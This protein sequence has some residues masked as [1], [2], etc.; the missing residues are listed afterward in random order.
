MRTFRLL[1]VMSAIC[2]GFTGV[3]L[4]QQDVVTLANGA[5]CLTADPGD[6]VQI[7]IYVR[8][9]SG[10]P[11]GEDQGAGNQIQSFAIGIS[12]PVGTL[13]AVDVAAAGITSGEITI[14]EIKTPP[15]P[16]PAGGTKSWV[17]SYSENDS[18]TTVEADLPFN[19]DAA[20]P[21]DLIG[22][23]TVTVAGTATPGS[24]I[25]ITLQVNTS[26]L[27]EASTITESTATGDLML[28][29]TCIQITAPTITNTCPATAVATGGTGTGTVT[30]DSPQGTD[31]VVTLTSANPAVATVPATRT[32]PAGSTS[33]NYTVTGVSA[34]TTM[35]TATLPAGI[36]GASDGCNVTVQNAI[37]TLTPD[38]TNV[39]VGGT[40]QMT[41][42][43]SRT[44][45]TATT[46]T[47]VSS[48]PTTATV[49]ASVNIPAGSTSANFNVTGVSAGNATITA[50]MPAG[51][52]GDTDTATVNV[53]AVTLTMTPATA[54]GEPGDT[55][56][57][58]VAL[59]PAQP[60]D[61]MVTLSSSNNAVVTVPASVTIPGGAASATFDA[62]IVGTGT[63]TITATAAGGATDSSTVTALALGCS[64]DPTSVRVGEGGNFSVTLDIGVAQASDVTVTL[65][66][67][68]T[69]V[70][71]VPASVIIPAGSS[72]ASFLVSGVGIGT[73]T[74]TSTLP[75]ALGGGTCTLPVET[76]TAQAIPTLSE[77]TMILLA[78]L[79]AIVGYVAL[80]P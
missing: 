30:I 56:T 36:G 34:G 65:A 11:L 52:G 44:F 49:P 73:T 8:D 63:A 33:V 62:D 3:A 70:A 6:V 32:I 7:P 45:G 5:A 48:D 51:K 42:T 66:S 39:S 27:N 21:G 15:N 59:N 43:M 80:K 19:L 55:I 31:T 61:T 74:V 22:M 40:A 68:D 26:L 29:S 37:V 13:T 46:I 58:T 78:G 18:L 79:L 1:A 38:P 10:T 54:T 76:A 12:Y 35:I 2:L 64:F 53:V 57:F 25:P 23:F 24:T 14:A 50:A 69:T 75:A 16:I 4:A 20:L 67:G 60:G 77:W 28:V 72:T 47:L 41:A 9:T 71:T 17:V